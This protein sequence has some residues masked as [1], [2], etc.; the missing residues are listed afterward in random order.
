MKQRIRSKLQKKLFETGQLK[1]K[2]EEVEIVS[3]EKQDLTKLLKKD[4][5]AMAKEMNLEG[6]SSRNTK[7][8]II[9]AIESAD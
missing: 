8:Q 5:L 4:L 2:P 1:L 3:E 6:I 7:V 9:A